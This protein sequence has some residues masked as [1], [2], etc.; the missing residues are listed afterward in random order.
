MK[1]KI[2]YDNN[3]KKGFKSGWGF[4][5]L[6][7]DE[8]KVLFDTGA[9]SETLLYN[10]KQLKIAPQDI[11]IVILSHLHGDHTGGLRKFLEANGNKAKIYR[12]SAFSKL[13]QICENIYSTGF[14]GSFLRI[15]E[16]SLIVKTEKGNTVITGCAHPGL[17]NIIE[18]ARQLGEIYSVIGG[19]HGFS[20]LEKL[21]SIELIAP[22]HCT[23]YIQEIKERFL[24]N[25]KE[26][27]A[28][29]VVEI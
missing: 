6:I 5:C 21:E 20:K 4:S 15:K 25:Y 7:E 1:I 26:I 13:T 14:L 3:A 29:S 8:E 24:T 12:P 2:V 23:Q 9:D 27:K 16:Q 28:G 18:K 11:D 10:M 19:F 17:E 22:C